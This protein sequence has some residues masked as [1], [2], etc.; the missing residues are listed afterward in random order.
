[1]SLASCDFGVQGVQPLLAH[2]SVPTEPVVDLRQRLGPQAVDAELRFVA[3]L[4][5][6]RLP[7]HPQVP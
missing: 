4:D 2:R 3:H 1:L 6:A 7:Q 5:Q